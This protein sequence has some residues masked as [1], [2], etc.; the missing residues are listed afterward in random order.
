MARPDLPNTRFITTPDDP[1]R[2]WKVRRLSDGTFKQMFSATENNTDADRWGFKHDRIWI[3]EADA[4]KQV[5]KENVPIRALTRDY[6]RGREL[7]E[8]GEA[9]P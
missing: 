9:A 5:A 8:G 2:V 7:V 4:A 6:D 1:S 3:T